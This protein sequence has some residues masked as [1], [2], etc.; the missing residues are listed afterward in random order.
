MISPESKQILAD[1]RARDLNFRVRF[2]FLVFAVPAAVVAGVT[3]GML[4]PW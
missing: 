2:W 3:L 1:V 4:F